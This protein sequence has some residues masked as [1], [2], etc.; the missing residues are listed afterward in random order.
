MNQKHYTYVKTVAEEGS[1]SRAA[2]KLFI[3]QP[4]L[5]QY[6]QR[7]ELQYGVP[8]FN[9]SHNTVSLTA[10]GVIYLQFGQNILEMEQDI[11]QKVEDLK[12]LKRGHLRIGTAPYRDCVFL[13]PAIHKFNQLYPGIEIKLQEMGQNETENRLAAGEIDVAITMPPRRMTG[14]RFTELF[15][16]RLLLAIA[17]DH[18]F[19]KVNEVSIYKTEKDYPTIHLADMAECGFIL[20][21]NRRILRNLEEATCKAAGF[22]PKV[23]L[24]T[25]GI[26]SVHAMAAAGL[27]AT[28]LPESFL[29]YS[30]IK[31]TLSY[32]YLDVPVPDF[33]IGILQSSNQELS[34]P[35]QRFIAIINHFFDEGALV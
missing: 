1:F 33:V 7:I 5:S 8:L 24:E 29:R 23:I 18:W 34:L 35:A 9:R 19:F 31:K 20:L 11:F 12:T 15:H 16:E 3:S 30:K 14:F 27:G 4:S 17:P 26:E 13:A 22:N 32:F 2:E 6:I 10:A 28:F 21:T 25:K